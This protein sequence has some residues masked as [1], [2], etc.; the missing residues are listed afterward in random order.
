MITD[1]QVHIWT[2]DPSA[3]KPADPEDHQLKH[4]NGFPAEELIAEMDATGLP[5]IIQVR[6]GALKHVRDFLRLRG[7]ALKSRRCR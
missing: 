3:P 7:K 6:P 1:S 4:P 5:Y 2:V